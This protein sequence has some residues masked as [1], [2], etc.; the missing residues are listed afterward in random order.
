MLKLLALCITVMVLP[1]VPKMT[2][3]FPGHPTDPVSFTIKSFPGNSIPAAKKQLTAPDPD[4]LKEGSWY[5]GAMKN[6]EQKEYEFHQGDSAGTYTTPNRYHNLRFQYSENGFTAQPRITKIPVGEVDATSRPDEVKYTT[7]PDWKVAFTLD[8]KQ[9]GNGTWQ[10]N[11]NQAEYQADN[12]TVQYLNN[13]EGM[14]QNFIVRKPLSAGNHLKLRFSIQTTLQQRLYSD[15]LQFIHPG[16]GVVLTYDQ[17]KVWDASGQL[18]EATFEKYNKDYCI[19]VQTQNAVYPITVDPISTTPAAMLESNQ[20][21]AWLGNSVASAGDVNGDGYS[22]VIVGAYSYSNGEFG[23]G[24]AFVY[25]GSAT[26]ISTIPAVTLES[27]QANANLGYSVAG[28]GDVNG[29]GYSDVI[30][31]AWQYDNGE[32]DEGVAF[33][34]HG[35]ATGISTIRLLCWK[36]TRPMPGWAIR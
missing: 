24:A 28:A 17:L 34:Y 9:T 22:D 33:T 16:S 19:H 7:L 36:A 10:I 25:H 35:S 4:M 11:G 32:T 1:V 26:G 27:N 14:R 30:V 18:L 12:I 20:A 6:L 2:N 21:S 5:T 31:G 13:E 3:D 23:E 8:K 29:D 15:R